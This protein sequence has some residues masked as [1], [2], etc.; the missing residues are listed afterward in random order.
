M[1]KRLGTVL[2]LHATMH[3]MDCHYQSL[4][5]WGTL[6]V[7]PLRVVW[8]LRV[9]AAGGLAPLVPVVT[10]GFFVTVGSC[11]GGVGS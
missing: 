6:V 11:A 9:G 3:N 8:G 1:N 4:N 5:R 10:L 2:Q 7:L